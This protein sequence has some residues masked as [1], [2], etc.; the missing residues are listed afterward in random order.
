MGEHSLPATDA[1]LGGSGGI[2]QQF[3]DRLG[4]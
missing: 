2:F 4:H 3:D 1:H